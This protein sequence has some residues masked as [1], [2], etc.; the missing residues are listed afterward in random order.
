M[1]NFLKN[2]FNLFKNLFNKRK[3]KT[4]PEKSIVRVPNK[5][6]AFRESLRV[7]FVKDKKKIRTLVCYGTGL[8]IHNKISY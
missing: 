6:D 1:T 8:G 3:I 7:D 2:I 4:I 5:N